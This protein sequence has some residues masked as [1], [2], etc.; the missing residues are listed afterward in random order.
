MCWCAYAWG[1]A[2]LHP[3]TSAASTR[4]LGTGSSGLPRQSSQ[5]RATSGSCRQTGTSPPSPKGAPPWAA[6]RLPRQRRS[7]MQ[8]R[9][10][11]IGAMSSTS[12]RRAPVCAQSYSRT[13]RT[14][15]AFQDIG[16]VRITTFFGSAES[17]HFT[18]KLLRARVSARSHCASCIRI[19]CRRTSAYSMTVRARE[20][21]RAWSR[22]T[23]LD[24]T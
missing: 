6:P 20:K 8:G 13:R 23:S 17:C 11:H 19:S 9:S 24:A 2:R 21:C 3:K 10:P 1:I 14:H 16:E 22:A 12:Q 5:G 4:I 15:L 18:P 7:D